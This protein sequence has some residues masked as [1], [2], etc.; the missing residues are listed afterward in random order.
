MKYKFKN[1]EVEGTLDQ[2]LAV[3]KILGESVNLAVLLGKDV[4]PRGYYHSS[5]KGLISMKEM[6]VPHLKN[7]IL[8][9]THDYF[10]SM[11]GFEGTT[12]EWVE[13]YLALT[14]DD[15]LGELFEELAS[16]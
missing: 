14:E 16:R 1:G 5:S 3:A 11:K 13:K 7:S 12:N 10:A 9:I 4:R 6:A 15:Q 2:I 8:K